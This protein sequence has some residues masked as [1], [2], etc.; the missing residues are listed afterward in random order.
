MSGAA[1]SSGASC[2]TGRPWA[3]TTVRSPADARRT[4]S[5]NPARSSLIPTVSTCVHNQICNG[6]ATTVNISP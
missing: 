4:A 5:A 2:A 3:V 6:A 1:S